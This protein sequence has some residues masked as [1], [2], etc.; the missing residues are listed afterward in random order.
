[1]TDSDNADA[2]YD[3]IFSAYDT[4]LSCGGPTTWL[5]SLL[6]NLV[7]AGLRCHVDVLL[8]DNP[9]PL[10]RGLRTLGVSHE[11]TPCKGT[12]DE[13]VSGILERLGR[14]RFRIFVPQNVVP[15]LHATRYVKKAGVAVVTV[16]H[17]DDAFYRGVIDRFV[18]GSAADRVTAAVAVSDY[19]GQL[20]LPSE[21]RCSVINYAVR[22]P[23]DEVL[24]R[25][26]KH[27]LNLV[28]VGRF[29]QPQKNIQLVV[30][31]LALAVREVPDCTATMIGSGPEWERVSGLVQEWGLDDRL[32]LT[33][34][35]N[36]D[37][38]YRHL[39]MSDCFVLLS[40]YEGLPIAL[41]EAMAF[42]VVPIVTQM[43]SGIPELIIHGET[44]L[45]VERT[46]E[47]FAETVRNLH[48][49]PEKLQR[50]RRGAYSH[51][52]EKYSFERQAA[53]WLSLFETL[54]SEQT[55]GCDRVRVP[56]T[57][58]LSDLH[59]ALASEEFRPSPK[60]Q[61]SRARVFI[62]GIARTVRRIFAKK[63]YP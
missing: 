26:E 22:I 53:S 57:I 7:R 2:D 32:K 58:E 35:C 20:C 14:K 4:N 38:V 48:T 42:G 52:R 46:A 28:Y 25:A 33:G 40:N 19:T 62:S 12:T 41:L 29:E 54:I 23:S 49:D 36:Q 18:K 45:I 30:E 1:M 27:G 55:P 43:E 60:P 10:C 39:R 13:R 31:S 63:K 51:I 9:G 24:Q 5:L 6:P 61:I 17:S 59:P 11:M 16:I 44:G 37:A 3:V 50:I 34:L 47:A 15:A 21:C 56:A 8:W